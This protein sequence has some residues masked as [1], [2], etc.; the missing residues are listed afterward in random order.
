LPGLLDG[1]QAFSVIGRIVV[2]DVRPRTPFG[3]FPAKAT[4]GRELV[5]S[6]DIVADGH[7]VL[8]AQAILRPVAGLSGTP[9][10]VVPL[11]EGDNDRF[12][13]RLRPAA[14]GRH[15]LVVE[16]WLSKEKAVLKRKF[17]Y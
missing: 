7:D 2:D 8:A 11:A 14:L 16:A 10:Q 6:A 13:G 3:D 4:L 5:V 1:V 9:V 12:V 17:G 15:E